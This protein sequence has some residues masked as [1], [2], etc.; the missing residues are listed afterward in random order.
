MN[1]N[2]ISVPP[3]TGKTTAALHCIADHVRRGMND[4][5]VGYI[6]YAAPTVALLEQSYDT[7]KSMLGSDEMLF[8]AISDGKG[9]NSNLEVTH[10]G[11]CAA[12]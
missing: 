5:E 6:F 10:L 1:L 3:G 12:H 9:V 7:L 4:K 2:Y 11:R 8:M